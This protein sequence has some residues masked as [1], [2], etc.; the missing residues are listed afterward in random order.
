MEKSPYM[1]A[2]GLE[3]PESDYLRRT[4]NRRG[5]SSMLADDLSVSAR[6]LHCRRY[7]LSPDAP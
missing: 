4:R 5:I 1:G 7:Q 2:L 6:R 3:L